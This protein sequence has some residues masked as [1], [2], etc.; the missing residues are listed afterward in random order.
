MV[1]D[2]LITK[3]VNRLAITVFVFGLEGSGMYE[4]ILNDEYWFNRDGI[5]G[6]IQG[7]SMMF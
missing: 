4:Y 3:S 2:I 6:K 7:L 5:K 1:Q